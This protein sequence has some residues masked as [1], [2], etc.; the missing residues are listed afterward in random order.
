MVG[1][2]LVVHVL[3]K[4]GTSAKGTPWMGS[5]S[6]MRRAELDGVDR[7]T[8]AARSLGVIGLEVAAAR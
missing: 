2:V 7:H 5:S 1:L 4:S 6:A 3:E 8:G